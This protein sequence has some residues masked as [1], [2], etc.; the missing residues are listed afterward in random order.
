MRFAQY[1]CLLGGLAFC[2]IPHSLAADKKPV[3]PE[4][5]GNW[6]Q[7]ARK[8]KS[9]LDLLVF[10]PAD[11]VSQL[12]YNDLIGHSGEVVARVDHIKGFIAEG[13]SGSL[14]DQMGAT[15]V[16][17]DRP[18]NPAKTPNETIA[19]R[20]PEGW[21]SVPVVEHKKSL[22]WRAAMSQISTDEF[23][24]SMT[25]LGR[26]RPPPRP[27]QR[28]DAVFNDAQIASMKNRLELTEEQEPYWQAVE[29]SLREVVWDRRHGIRPRLEPSS[30]DRF[31]EAAAPLMATLSAKQRSKIEALANIVG[32]RLGRQGR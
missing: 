4:A 24:T 8:G 26:L 21:E 29:V 3:H 5:D 9:T 22:L 1:L 23:I 10:G 30:L 13:Y 20:F 16:V 31:K 27:M 12:S 14:Q 6:G 7:W 2:A 15:A 18:I 11:I 17:T 25:A 28:P 32:L 19:S